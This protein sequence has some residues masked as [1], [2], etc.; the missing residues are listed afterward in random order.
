M[1]SIAGSADLQISRSITR[2]P[3][4][5]ITRFCESQID[6]PVTTSPDHE[7]LRIDRRLTTSQDLQMSPS[8][9]LPNL[10]R[11]HPWHGLDIGPEPPE[12]V[13]AFIEIT[14]FDHMK[15]EVDKRSGYL[16]V[17]RPQRG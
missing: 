15:Y 3:L 10:F 5:Q 7:I 9:P 17:D 13:H 12:I 6:H 16:Q 4:H 2:S 14:P 1:R 8:P 11:P